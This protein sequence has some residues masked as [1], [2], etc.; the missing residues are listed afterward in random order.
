MNQLGLPFRLDS[1]MLLSNLI[2]E[3][4]K[5]A[6]SFLINLFTEKSSNIVY[7]YGPKSSGK[8]H[9]LQGCAFEA[10]ELNLKV[11]YIDFLQD[12]PDEVLANLETYDWVIIDNVEQL[13]KLQQQD[14]FSLY[15]ASN[16][17]GL[18][19]IISAKVL[20]SELKILK[21]LKTRLSLAT[22]FSLKA[23]DDV[24]KQEI[25]KRHVADKNLKIDYHIY[26]YLFK[27][28]SRDLTDLLKLIELLD[29]VSL[30]RKSNI[31]IPLVK[32]VLKN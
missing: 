19:L 22:I 9:I 13:N 31:T 26:D 18:K 23:P 24:T 12:N 8:T 4:N 1:K 30:Q 32:Q 11:F 16:S 25:I 10:L 7:I 6:V 15:N 5:Q 29:E 17:K 3:K 27:H 14:L 28:Y 2:K 21:D 20:P